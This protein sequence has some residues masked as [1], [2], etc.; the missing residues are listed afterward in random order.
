M[1]ISVQYFQSIIDTKVAFQL[2]SRKAT[3]EE[4]N[5][6]ASII[7]NSKSVIMT[8]HVFSELSYFLEKDFGW[9]KLKEQGSF[10][11]L[12]KISEAAVEKNTI[13]FHEALEKFGVVD[14][15]MLVLLQTESP[16]ATLISYDWDLVN[17]CRKNKINA[18]HPHEIIYNF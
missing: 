11:L 18:L 6:I 12:T 1:L 5:V 8:P 7:E 16:A 4:K 14:A 15:S 10:Q 3:P 9:K 13:L 17:W 2:F